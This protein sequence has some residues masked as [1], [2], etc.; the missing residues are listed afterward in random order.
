MID[1]I[2]RLEPIPGR[3]APNAPML[4]SVRNLT[5]HGVLATCT[6]RPAS[7]LGTLSPAEHSPRLM[8]RP[9]ASLIRSTV[10]R[11]DSQLRLFG[12]P[13]WLPV[14]AGLFPD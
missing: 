7:L 8:T 10:H 14:S 11:G 13:H 2:L 9:L 1:G 12:G 5:Y 3:T 6:D 4:D